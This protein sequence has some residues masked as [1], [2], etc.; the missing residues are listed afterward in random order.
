MWVDN[1][2]NLAF[3]DPLASRY[4]NQ[5]IPASAGPSAMLAPFWDDLQVGSQPSQ[6]YV[7]RFVASGQVPSHWTVQY[8][9]VT[10]LAGLDDLNFEVKLFDDGTIEFHYADMT[11]GSPD[12]FADGNSATIWLCAPDF[13]SA[14]P[15]GLD[16]AVIQPHSAWRFTP[17]P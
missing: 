8:A 13:T 2:G 11:S 7:K 4:V 9:H 3:A 10:H 17:H 6:V 1:N 16:Q 5:T 15:I 12:H 14:L